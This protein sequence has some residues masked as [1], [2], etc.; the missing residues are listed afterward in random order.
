MRLLLDADTLVF[1]YA[2][3]KILFLGLPRL[4]RNARAVPYAYDIQQIDPAALSAAQTKYLAPYDEQLAALNFR[5]VCTYRIANFG[6]NLQRNYVAPDQTS[7]CVVLIYERP[8]QVIGKPS[9]SSLCVMSF[10]TRFIDSTVLTTRN[11]HL[12][13]FEQPPYHIVQEFPGVSA[14]ELKRRHDSRAASMGHAVPP[15]ADPASTFQDIQDEHLRFNEY[16]LAQGMVKLS[17]DGKCF[18]QTDKLFW[19]SIRNYLNPF[20]YRFSLR[21]F[22][23]AGILAMILPLLALAIAPAVAQAARGIGF[24][25]ELARQS[26]ILAGYFLA[27]AVLGYVLERKTFIWVFLLTYIGVRIVSAAPL[28]PLPYSAF[29]GSA[30][31]TVAQAKKRRRAVLLPESAV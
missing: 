23:P 12:S 24:P 9:V 22:V 27:G 7:R 31:Y 19:R 28:G 11:M 6:Y 17:S 15:P 2:V 21:R 29:A 8:L 4:R 20:A 5:Q 3:G 10:H 16:Q 14:A 1:F 25:A 26:V 13:A 30:A 18:V